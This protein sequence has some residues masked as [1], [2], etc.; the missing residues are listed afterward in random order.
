MKIGP[1]DV[2]IHACEGVCNTFD[3]HCMYRLEVCAVEGCEERAASGFL[4]CT[5]P[6]HRELEDKRR[7]R[8]SANFQ[9]KTQIQRSTVSNPPDEEVLQ[10]VQ[11]GEGALDEG[12]EQS[13]LP[14]DP[15]QGA[16]GCPQ[17]PE[18]GNRR[19]RA[20]FWRSQT[21]KE[22]L[23]V[24]LCGIIVARTTFFGSETVPQ[25]VVRC[26]SF[27]LDSFLTFHLYR[28]FSRRFSMFLAQ[29]PSTSSMTIA[30]GYTITSLLRKTLSSKPSAF[31]LTPSI[32]TAS[33]AGLTSFAVSTVTHSCFQSFLST[34]PV[35]EHSISTP[36]SANRSMF[37]WAAIMLFFG[38]CKQIGMTFFS[39]SLL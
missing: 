9:M 27:I 22:Q 13:I 6:S 33:T 10:S 37:G 38:R 7:A 15:Q 11:E 8:N 24:R 1:A 26:L 14:P 23:L 35:A 16:S 19:I 39:T 3:R 5:L 17:K 28:H 21:H 34:M 18:T 29:C 31:L 36:Q 12:V 4:T 25:I 2:K 30:V 20:R 32:M